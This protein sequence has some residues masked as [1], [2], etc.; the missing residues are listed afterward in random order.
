MFRSVLKK[1]NPT[2]FTVAFLRAN[3]SNLEGKTEII[4]NHLAKRVSYSTDLKNLPIVLWA[5]LIY[6]QLVNK[7]RKFP[8]RLQEG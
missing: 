8:I 6:A 3:L 5:V 2:S 1:K 4:S 7:K